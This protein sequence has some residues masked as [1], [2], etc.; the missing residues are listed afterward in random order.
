MPLPWTT[1]TRGSPARKARSTNF[2]T[3]RVASS[4]VRPMTL[5]SAGVWLLFERHGNAA[6][7]GGFYGRVGGAGDDFGDVGAG[8]LHFHCAYFDFEVIVVDFAGDDRG[9]SDGFQFDCVAL[10]DVLHQLR[11]RVGIA[12]V[13]AGGVRYYRGIELLAKFAA[14]FGDA[15]LGVFGELLGGGAVLHGVD[16]F[17]GVIFEVA[18]H[19]FQLLF[20]FVEFG[21]LVFAAFAARRF[22][23]AVVLL[24]ACAGEGARFRCRAIRNAGD[25]EIRL[26]RGPG[27]RGGRG[28]LR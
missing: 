12:L 18:K 25:L 24:H 2:S 8:D 23:R 22:S 3:S 27:C 20:H 10:G 4:T 16:G 1:R 9:A 17:A 19:G 6:G 15:A 14:Q 7:A 26:R 11:L 5:I 28:R 21:L 13:G